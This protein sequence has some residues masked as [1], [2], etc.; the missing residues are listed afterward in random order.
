M[1]NVLFI[2]EEYIRENTVFNLNVDIKDI[3]QSAGVA[4]DMHI[5]PILGTTFYNYLET[6]YSAQT[7]TADEQELMSYIKPALA[8]QAAQMTLPFLAYNVKN[9]GPVTQFGENA[10]N[11]DAGTFHFLRKE[12]QNR[13]E[14]YTQRLVA[15]LCKNANLFPL[16]VSSENASNDMAPNHQKSGY[17]NQIGLYPNGCGWGYIDG[18]GAFKRFI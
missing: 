10:T 6:A 4:Q 8:Y 2:G 1:A 18:T 11:V 7:L 12:I 5:Q 17:K 16:Y 15:Y 3:E 13:A 14:F 9:K